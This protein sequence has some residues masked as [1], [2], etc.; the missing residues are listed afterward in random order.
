MSVTAADV[1]AYVN[2]RGPALVAERPY[3]E[4]ATPTYD[5]WRAWLAAVF[6]SHIRPP[7]APYHEQFWQWA[8]EIKAGESSRP[9]VAIWPRGFGKST[10]VEVAVAMLAA[11]KARRYAL[12]VC[13]TQEQADT[14][15]ANVASLLE[16]KAF[17]K[18]F[19]ATARRRLG[20]YG[21]SQGW[22]RNR[23]R[24]ESGFTID[25]IGLDTAA[26]GAK[27]DEDRPDLII[28]DDV[29]ELLDSPGT[30]DKKEQLITK[31][32]IPARA[33]HAAVLVAQNLIHADGIVARLAN[34][35]ATY[36]ADREVSGPH[37]AID[38]LVTEQRD[39]KAV[40]V[41][42]EPTWPAK[43]IPAL[44]ADMDDIG[45]SAFLSEK[46]HEV[47]VFEGGIFASVVFRHCTWDEL[48]K[49]ERVCVWVDPAVTDTDKSDSHGIHADGIAK[50]T[51]YRLYSW[52][53]RTSPDDSMRRAIL[54][55]VELGATSV[56]VETD[57]GGD[58][59]K[60]T[61]AAVAASLVAAG[62]ITAAQVPAFKQ[63]KAGS[64]HGPKAHRATHML[65][66]YERGKIVHVIGTHETLERALKRYLLR[67]P[68]D[69]VDA[70]Y[71]AWFD[72]TGGPKAPPARG[73]I[74]ISKWSQP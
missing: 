69:L 40:I 67:K 46:Q 70:S 56:G 23:L 59:W 42:G 38:N 3:R 73:M 4:R 18:H 8:W 6:A 22:R 20:K 14:H 63:D 43:D 26:R 45:L 19:P 34:G 2:A 47:D 58:T 27:V 17:A 35:T 32:I 68:F 52:E 10:S 72:L 55:A 50:G 28:F 1:R 5:D 49:L 44:Q 15:V 11:R 62:T 36:L 30:V 61:Y 39:G 65:A 54:K 53:A 33:E 13:A 41:S 37:K 60:S 51:L 29:D 31:S 48:P 64:G 24:T 9:F 7:F 16:S 21:N 25:A 12:Y 66:D 71:Y 74:Q 57:Q